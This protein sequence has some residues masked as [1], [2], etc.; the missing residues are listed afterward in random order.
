MTEHVYFDRHVPKEFVDLRKAYQAGCVLADPQSIEYQQYSAYRE[1]F[2]RVLHKAVSVFETDVGDSSIDSVRLTVR[3]IGTLIARYGVDQKTYANLW[4]GHMYL[5]KQA[6]CW[7]RQKEYPRYIWVRRMEIYH[8][9]RLRLNAQR[10]T[11]SALD[12]SLVKDLVSLSISSFVKVRK[13]AQATLAAVCPMYDGLVPMIVPLLLPHLKAGTDPDVMKGTIYVLAFSAITTFAIDDHRFMAPYILTILNGQHQE[14]PSV[15]S[16]IGAILD[17]ALDLMQEP[18][19][20]LI[21][22]ECDKGTETAMKALLGELPP[23]ATDPELRQKVRAGVIESKQSLDKAYEELTPQLLQIAE[24]NTTHWKYAVTTAR[25]LRILLRRDVATSPEVAK[26][27]VGKIPDSQP[28]LRAQA[29]AATT[30]ILYIIKLRTLTQGDAKALFLQNT[31][32]PLKRRIQPDTTA[33]G[34]TRDVLQR[35]Q[36]HVDPKS[37]ADQWMQDKSYVGWLCWGEDIVQSRLAKWDEDV[38]EWEEASQPAIDAMK[39][40][41]DDPQWWKDVVSNWSQEKTRQYLSSDNIDL[42]RSICQIFKSMAFRHLKPIMEELIEI[43]DKDKQRALA[44]LVSGLSRG[45]KHWCGRDRTEYW[46]WLSAPLPKIYG[47]IRPDTFEFWK[48]CFEHC[49]FQQDPRRVQPVMT[50]ILETSR[51]ADYVSGSAFEIKKASTML[52]SLI[53][54]YGWRFDSWSEEFLQ[55]YFKVAMSSDFEEVRSTVSNNIQLL[56]DSQW[57]PSYASAKEF[58]SDCVK[59]PGKDI[60]GTK[61][62]LGGHLE[63]IIAQF[64]QWREERP[65]GPQAALSTYDK[66]ASTV[67]RWL[68]AGFAEIHAP[69]MFAYVL[70]LLP[71]IFRMREMTGSD[72]QSLSSSALLFTTSINPPVDIV[73]PLLHS[74][75]TI[76]RESPQWKIRL[77]AL[78]VLSI[79]Y[80]RELP[81]V[82]EEL[83]ALIM[84]VLAKCLHDENQEVRETASRTLSGVLRCSQRAS[85][86]VLKDRFVRQVKSAKLPRKR[87][88]DGNL[89][90]AYQ[91]AVKKLHGAILGVTAV[92]EAFPYTVPKFIPELLT[93]VL[94]EHASDPNP[95][96][97][98][99]RA[100]AASFQRSHADTWHQDK[101]KFT[102]DQLSNLSYVISGTSYCKSESFKV[103]S[104]GHGHQ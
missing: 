60:I 12:D 68:Y 94:A 89:I 52:N 95:I 79:I 14:K 16:L 98:T 101:L 84:D 51:T 7:P 11:R 23:S 81:L 80:Y 53:R 73:E 58:M 88:Q 83:A 66:T 28:V 87:D 42:L 77:H 21:G 104:C 15:Q 59:N 91:D 78:P 63:K 18:I 55:L 67:L 54:C 70:P 8:S 30:R 69:A 64:P 6:R 31:K 56:D 17:K 86:T 85:I 44:E 45:V 19:T 76:L 47:S 50:F 24:S 75:L 92:I 34:F 22:Q 97:S 13:V 99:I 9:A 1:R 5:E 90:P 46:D 2:G 61:G 35:F 10:R 100:C 82:D 26:Y 103:F 102:E 72:I 43:T 57:H 62:H 39:T 71:E 29:Q 41:I 93:E 49:L 40:F 36:E 32:N 27:F 3:S 38:F 33:D 4:K 37:E 74:T 20:L 48:M 96:S 25:L 65:S